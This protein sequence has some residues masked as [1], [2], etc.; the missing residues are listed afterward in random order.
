ML[1]VMSFNIRCETA[2]DGPNRWDA[3]KKMVVARIRA[4]DPDVLGIQ[5]CDDNRQARYLRRKL[6]DYQMVTVRR[7]G[8]GS[9]D[10]EMS[11]VL[12]RR[13]CFELLEQGWLWLSETPHQPGSK[14]WGAHFPRTLIWVRLR[15]REAPEQTVLFCNTHLDYATEAAR[16]ESARVISE[17]VRRQAGGAAVILS[18][19]FNAEPGSAAYRRLT[20]APPEGAGLVDALRGDGRPMESSRGTFHGFGKESNYPAIDWLMVSAGIR[21]DGSGVDTWQE[22]ERY[23]SDHYPIYATI[24]LAKSANNLQTSSS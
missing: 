7:G 5:E 3:R 4:G 18:G 21:V 14:D 8:R 22:G 11:P 17:F 10:F 1:K 9:P 12:F 13:E 20:G 6:A 2:P 16:T 24:N 15:L 23:P 19:D